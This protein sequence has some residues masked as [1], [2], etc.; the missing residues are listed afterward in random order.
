MR[1]PGPRLDVAD[2]D[3]RAPDDLETRLELIGGRKVAVMDRK[4]EVAGHPARAVLEPDLAVVV[5]RDAPLRGARPGGL[6]QD[7]RRRPA[8]AERV[9]GAVHPVVHRPEQVR[10]L[11]LHAAAAPEAG[12]EQ[13]LP[14]RG[15]VAV[16]VGVLPHFVVVRLG[17]EDRVG[18]EGHRE[19][20]EQQVVDEDRVA[21]ERVVAVAV[22]VQRDA[23][24]RLERVDAVRLLL[25]AAQLE[26]EHPAV[27]VERDLPRR[28][29][30][31]LGE[32]R[33]EAIA[34]RQPELLRL[35]LG[36]ERTHRRLWRQVRV[37]VG[38]VLRIR[39]R[40]GA[41]AAAGSL[42]LARPSLG[43]RPQRPQQR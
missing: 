31:G 19:A 40:A 37:C 20:R 14:V 10:R 4:L 23:A 16:G 42:D 22:L 41:A 12:R 29:D 1:V 21:L 30:D 25:V 15:A 5:L 11:R 24:D 8:E 2:E 17:G 32:H 43:V 35:F 13:V 39:G 38:R 27:A 18:A 36:R 33:F 26:D 28:L 6:A 3:R 34:G 7:S 9:H